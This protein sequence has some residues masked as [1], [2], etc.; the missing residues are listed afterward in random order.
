MTMI[1]VIQRDRKLGR[2]GDKRNRP[3]MHDGQRWTRPD[4]VDYSSRAEMIET[5]LGP[6]SGRFDVYRSFITGPRDGSLEVRTAG[7]V[8]TWAG[9]A[10]LLP[11][12]SP[13]FLAFAGDFELA[14]IHSVLWEPAS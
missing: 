7:R 11:D 2:R 4:G 14:G 10:A 3:W 9:R 5:T 12:R 8:T 13:G 6:E 1:T